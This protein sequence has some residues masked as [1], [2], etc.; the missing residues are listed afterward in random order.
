MIAP[1]RVA[2]E[3]S[4]SEMDSESKKDFLE[5]LIIRRELADNFCY[6]E[7]HYDSP[8]GFHEY[9]KKEL[10]QNE[11]VEREYLYTKKEFE[12]A[13]TH[14]DLWNACQLQMVK[15]GK[16]HGYLRM[17]WAKMIYAWSKNVNEAMKIAIYLN[18]TYELDGRDPNGYTGIAWCIGGVHDRPWYV[19]NPVFGNGMNNFRK[20]C[21]KNHD[22][23]SPN[24]HPNHRLRMCTTHPHSFYLEILSQ[25]GIVGLLLLAIFFLLFL[26]RCFSVFFI[27]K[28]NY[29]LLSGTIIILCY[30]LP[31]PR[32]SF[33]T[34]WN[35]IIFWLTF[36]VTYSQI[37][38]IKINK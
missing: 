4:K 24:V 18:D 33:F 7:S 26:I 30:F 34:N 16:M 23:Y 14:D 12:E 20:D 1:Q 6:Y 31:I 25:L 17:Y 10:E 35:A 3:V 28:E 15:T 36:G 9:F 29:L 32:G 11:K 19:T 8:E 37:L 2:L 21:D 22:I 13:Q 5:E 27:K 38:F